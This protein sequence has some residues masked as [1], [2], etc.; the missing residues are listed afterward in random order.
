MHLSIP[1]NTRASAPA[2]GVRRSRSL[3]LLVA[4]LALWLGACGGSAVRSTHS[5][6]TSATS[7]S[8]TAAG[9]SGQGGSATTTPSAG[10]ASSQT[11]P[12]QGAGEAENLTFGGALSGRL[13]ATKVLSCG[14][15]QQSTPPAGSWFNL[16]I[17][18]SLGNTSYTF[19]INVA[20]GTSPGSYPTTGGLP[21]D[22]TQ[23]TA[24]ILYSN[25]QGSGLNVASRSG[26]TVIIDPGMKSGSVDATMD[27]SAQ[28]QI[29]GSGAP[30]TTVTVRGTWKCP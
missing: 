10:A 29:S 22:P 2:V 28:A 24:V 25:D 27:D 4:W 14:V 19:G 12:A 21:T 26:G 15:A 17:T 13:S 3:A 7:A 8:G 9:T 16:S 11:P 20:K 5:S 18:G 23:A 6:P 30:V 1:G